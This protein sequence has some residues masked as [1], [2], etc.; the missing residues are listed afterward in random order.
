MMPVARTIR[1]NTFQL[2][3]LESNN[4]IRNIIICDCG[5]T[6]FELYAK[7]T[8]KCASCGALDEKVTVHYGKKNPW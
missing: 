7:G 4:I 1:D 6:T 5:C 3:E 2:T 8:V